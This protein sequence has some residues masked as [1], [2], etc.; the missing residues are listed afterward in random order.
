MYALQAITLLWHC[1][2]AV[3]TTWLICL[4]SLANRSG[5]RLL[6][7]APNRGAKWK[8]KLR[9]SHGVIARNPAGRRAIPG[10][11]ERIPLEELIAR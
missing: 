4:K 6:P 3:V 9:R 2:A 11:A 5:M 8:L 10:P 7:R 1:R